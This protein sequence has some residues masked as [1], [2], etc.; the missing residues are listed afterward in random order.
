MEGSPLPLPS[1]AVI[2]VCNAYEA[3]RTDLERVLKIEQTAFSLIHARHK[4]ESDKKK[5]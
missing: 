5:V 2:S 4:A 3:D 1:A